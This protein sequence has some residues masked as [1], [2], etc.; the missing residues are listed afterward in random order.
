MEIQSCFSLLYLHFILYHPVFSTSFLRD[1]SLSTVKMT[2]RHFP[3]ISP[4]SFFL[5]SAILMASG[6]RKEGSRWAAIMKKVFIIS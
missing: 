1:G 5:F 3:I 2:K 6:I 4:F